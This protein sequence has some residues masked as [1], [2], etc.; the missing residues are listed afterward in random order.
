MLGDVEITFRKFYGD[1]KPSTVRTNMGSVTIEEWLK[2]Y[3]LVNTAINIIKPDTFD[4]VG[5]LSC[6]LN[7]YTTIIT[8]DKEYTQNIIGCIKNISW[9][10]IKAITKAIYKL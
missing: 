1:T 2:W 8:L 7:L 6:N 4:D 10:Q 5:V 3:K 9:K